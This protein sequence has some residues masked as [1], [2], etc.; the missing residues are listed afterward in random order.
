M[1]I[2][3]FSAGEMV[4]QQG[5][6]G[7]ELFVVNTGK[8]SCSKVFSGKKESTFLLNYGPGDAFGELALLYNAPRAA[9]IKADSDCVL[10]SLDRESFNLIVKEAVIKR[11]EAF[12]EFL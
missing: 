1:S 8:L 2:K 11:R 7:N 12:D 5:D 10:Y 3:K 6:D 9:S 4:I